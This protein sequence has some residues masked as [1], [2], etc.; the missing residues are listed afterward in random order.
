MINNLKQLFTIVL[1]GLLTLTSCDSKDDEPDEAQPDG[2]AL[3]QRFITNRENAKQTFTLDASTGGMVTGSQ[4]TS[5]IIPANSIGLNGVPVTGNIDI[6]LIEIYDK[7][8]MVLQNMSSKGKRANGDEEALK[9]AGEFF[10]NAKQNGNQLEV[11]TPITIESRGVAPGEYEPMQVF[12][13][14]DNIDDND[15][16]KEAD[17]DND[18]INDN[19]EGRE[20]QGPDGEF[21]L[22]SALDLSEFGW[23]NL[24]IWYNF[25]GQLTDLFVDTPDGYNSENT[26]VYLS[27]NGENGLARM[28]IYDTQ[29]E[30][31]T[32]HFG[33]IPVGQEVHFIMVVDIA[34]QLHYTIQPATIIEDHIEVMANPQ[35]I[36]QADLT[37]LINGLP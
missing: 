34:G 9:S 25:T 21:I 36:S 14:G 31:F 30:L 28:D 1:I 19:A 12:R 6:E 5:V 2:T 29:L 11:L 32:E 16:W 33:R 3:N 4:G 10:L 35:P 37:T 13:A 7:A 8:A 17:E 27:Y 15:I 18:G 20:G 24:D 26:S 23:T 22:F